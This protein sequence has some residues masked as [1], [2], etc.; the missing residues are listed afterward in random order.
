MGAVCGRRTAGRVV[1]ALSIVDPTGFGLCGRADGS[2]PGPDAD[3]RRRGSSIDALVSKVA[4]GERRFAIEA[5]ARATQECGRDERAIFP[6]L[7]RSVIGKR[8]KSR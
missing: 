3:R 5:R 6:G 2:V 8:W 4:A 1:V 7:D